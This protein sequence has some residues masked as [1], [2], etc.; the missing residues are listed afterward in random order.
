MGWVN[1][2]TE[3]RL[4]HVSWWTLLY[5]NTEVLVEDQQI[6][7]GVPAW[8]SPLLEGIEPADLPTKLISS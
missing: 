1:V 5:T 3:L 8:H 2:D 6:F 7:W 4:F